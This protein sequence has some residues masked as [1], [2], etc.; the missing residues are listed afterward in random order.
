MAQLDQRV[1]PD[2]SSPP[3]VTKVDDR[4]EV[5]QVHRAEGGGGD[6][7]T[8]TLVRHQDGPDYLV[9]GACSG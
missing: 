3:L 1:G 6:R 5:R 8:A 7:Y 2:Q 9:L 4:T